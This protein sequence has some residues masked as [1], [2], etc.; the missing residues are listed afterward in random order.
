MLPR[1]KIYWPFI[2][3]ML[4]IIVLVLILGIYYAMTHP[5]TVL[6]NMLQLIFSIVTTLVVLIIFRFVFGFKRDKA[7][8]PRVF[9]VIVPEW[10]MYLGDFTIA[11]IT[12]V[13]SWYLLE[14][15][16]LFYAY[17]LK[18]YLETQGILYIVFLA[19]IIIILVLST[20]GIP[21]RKK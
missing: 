14:D 17:K 10:V 4:I 3:I 11:A 13:I 16:S 5:V 1:D 12:L 6:A 19:I 9:G 18:S 15:L 21:K 2:K 20:V 7:G 8:N